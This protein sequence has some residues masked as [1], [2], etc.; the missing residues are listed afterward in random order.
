MQKPRQDRSRA[1]LDKLLAATKAVLSERPAGQAP[2]AAICRRAGLTTGAVYRRFPGKQALLR[3]VYGAFL[4]EMKARNPET[5]APERWGDATLAELARG[6][7]ARMVAQYRAQRGFLRAFLRYAE[8]ADA[9]FRRKLE[10]ANA[11][12]FDLICELLLSRRDEIA[13]PDPRTAVRLG[14]SVV[15][16]GLR[17]MIL[18]GDYCV[19]LSDERLTDELAALLLAYLGAP[20]PR[21]ARRASAPRRRAGKRKAAAAAGGSSL[22][23]GLR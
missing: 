12:T 19:G 22:S 5:L 4:D 18:T 15:S 10:E 8:T 16:L 14:M 6:V 13:H 11:G 7:I 1:T 3:H 21:T 20:T 17:E 9:R 23:R 2:I